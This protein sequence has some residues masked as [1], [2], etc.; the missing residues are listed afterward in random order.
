MLKAYGFL[1][2]KSRRMKKGKFFLE[3]E[4]KFLEKEKQILFYIN[5]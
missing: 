3:K 1:E 4:K 5:I 2:N